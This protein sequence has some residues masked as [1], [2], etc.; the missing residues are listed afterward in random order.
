MIIEG[1]HMKCDA[2]PCHNQG[3]CTED[4]MKGEGN[5]NCEFTSYFGPNCAEEKGA[6]FNGDSYLSRKLITQTTKEIKAQLAFSTKEDVIKDYKSLL[7]LIDGDTES[8]IVSLDSNGVLEI[9]DNIPNG[10]WA[11]SL[12]NGFINGA[13]HSVFYYRSGLSANL[14]VDRKSVELIFS[15]K[16][17]E[18]TDEVA[19]NE[20][21]NTDSDQE[22]DSGANVYLGGIKLSDE[23][24]FKQYRNYSGCLSSKYNL[25]YSLKTIN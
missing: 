2:K 11:A 22:D 13:R 25:I 24:K 12:N 21:N 3:I 7:L 9:E 1:C 15:S 10:K 6:S 5:C 16:D 20:I 17:Y 8:F 23:E 19:L 18:V 4:F 14:L